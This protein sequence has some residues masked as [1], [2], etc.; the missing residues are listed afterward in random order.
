[1]K[2][3]VAVDLSRH[4]SLVIKKAEELARPLGAEVWVL[5]VAEPEP[6]FV[7]FDVGP[8]HERD[9]RAAVFHEE[10]IEVQQFA[11]QLRSADIEATALL[12]QGATAETILD[13]SGRLDADLIVVG[14]HGHGAM[15]QLLVGSTSEG[16]IRDSQC[17][18]MIVPTPA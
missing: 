6:D 17:P 5:H 9:A 13:Q 1:M 8:Q 7:G 4:S 15:Y 11:D 3:L 2:I 12:V 16:V 10:H 14:S 18:V